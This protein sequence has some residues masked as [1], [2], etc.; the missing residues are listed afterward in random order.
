MS[1]WLS[2]ASESEFWLS[3]LQSSI[4]KLFQMVQSNLVN[5]L[6]QFA[7]KNQFKQLFDMFVILTSLTQISL[8]FSEL[9]FMLTYCAYEYL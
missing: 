4:C 9:G 1:E 2:G 8:L 5:W 7:K 3:N 6:I